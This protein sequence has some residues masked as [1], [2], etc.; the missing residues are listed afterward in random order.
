[1]NSDQLLARCPGLTYRRLDLWVRSGHLQPEGGIGSGHSR[2]FPPNE[3]RVAQIMTKLVAVSMS[4]D[5]IPAIELA[6]GVTLVLGDVNRLV[7]A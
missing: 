4:P 3:V 1:M 5:D 7:P 6:P 2:T